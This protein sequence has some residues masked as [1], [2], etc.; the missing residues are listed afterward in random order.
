[1]RSSSPLRAA[2][3]ATALTF[4]PLMIFGVAR[5]GTNVE[6]R[7]INAH[8]SVTLALDPALPLLNHWRS[9]LLRMSGLPVGSQLLSQAAPDY[10]FDVGTPRALELLTD[11]WGE[12]SFTPDEERVIREDV[13]RRASLEDASLGSALSDI[14]CATAAGGLT[15]IFVRIQQH[16]MVGAAYPAYVGSKEVWAMDL[17]PAISRVLPNAK[18]IMVHRDPRAVVASMQEIAI[19]D[20]L[21][22]GHVPSYLRHWRKQVALTSMFTRTTQLNANIHSI[23]YEDLVSNPEEVLTGIWDFLDMEGATAANI[24]KSLRAWGGNSSFGALGGA[25][26][27]TRLESWRSA[28]SPE[29]KEF[30]EFL[31]GVEMATLG[32]QVEHFSG[33]DPDTRLMLK[34]M[35]GYNTSPASWRSDSGNAVIDLDHELQRITVAR[36]GGGGW[37]TNEI[38]RLFLTPDVLDSPSTSRTAGPKEDLEA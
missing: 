17:I 1:M 38:L 10:Y 13:C 7:A 6:C 3:S 37:P 18:F 31:V 8:E 12:V 19:R 34:L 9:R 21:Q 27:K 11:E 33:E 24:D 32:Y 4:K 14:P 28:L 16:A 36:V 5:G 25:F 29:A 35:E 26:D 2:R 15:E 30:V 20:P 22:G 23:R